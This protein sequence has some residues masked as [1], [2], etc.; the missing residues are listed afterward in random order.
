MKKNTILNLALILLTALVLIIL[1]FVISEIHLNMVIEAAFFGLFAVSFNLLFGYAGML[2]FGHA[3]YFGI[4]GYCTVFALEYIKDMPLLLSI[5]IGGL[6]AAIGGVVI[7]FFCVRRMGAYF[8]LL[9]LAFNQLVF[10]IAF[11]WRSLTGGADGIGVTKPDLHLPLIG[12]IDMMRT[13]PMYYLVIIVVAICLLGCWAVLR[14]PFGNSVRCVKEN[15]ERA[16]F[17]GYNAFLVKLSIFSMS[18]F[19]AGIAGSLFVLFEEF[20]STDAIDLYMA[21]QVIFMAFIGGV[22]SFLGP[23]LGAGVFIYF[24]EW[25]SSITERWEFFLGLLFIFLIMFAH[26]GLVD[27]IPRLR[28]ALGSSSSSS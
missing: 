16:R 3:A 9:T 24:T 8:A 27:L 17:I 2:S 14:T 10:A 15:E 22:G 1:P 21:T 6:A 20:V 13:E 25:I 19:F 7:G 28:T 11:K 4:G 26:R 5:L 12:S 18:A 23:V